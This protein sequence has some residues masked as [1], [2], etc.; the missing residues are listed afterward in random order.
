MS[1]AKRIYLDNAATSW[2]KPTVVYEAVDTYQRE[3]GASAGRASYGSAQQSLQIVEYARTACQQL[4]GI[5]DPRRL[6][7]CSNGT[8]ALNVAIH[9]LLRPGDHVVTSVCEHNSVLRPLD[10]Q[11]KYHGVEVTYLP[12]DPNGY[13]SVEEVTQAIRSNT[14]LIVVVHASNVTGA[15]Q[16]IGDVIHAAHQSGAQ[17]LVDAAQTAGCV[18]IDVEQ[19]DIDLLATGGHKGLLGPLG[20]GLLYIRSGLENQLQ[21]L[22]QGGTGTESHAER[23]PEEMPEKFESG[24][25]NLPALAGLGSAARFLLERGVDALN[26]HHHKLTKQLLEG[27]NVIGGLT[28]HGPSADEPRVGVVSFAAQGYDPHEF[29]AALDASCRVE[30]RAGLHCAPRMHAQLG[31]ADSGGLIRLSPGWSTTSADIDTVLEAV[32]TVAS[33]AAS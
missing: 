11:K 31:T 15:I 12:C 24:N 25:L 4:L 27:L 13:V 21:T 3:I 17:V 33:V 30:C 28:I 16:P 6:L 2:P 32:A 22:R 8:D 23:H 19:L 26:H 14:R 1:T 5:K 20:T 18:P 29:A 10:W 9:G 7:F